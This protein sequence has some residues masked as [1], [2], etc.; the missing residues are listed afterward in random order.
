MQ[1]TIEFVSGYVRQQ[2]QQLE[3]ASPQSFAMHAHLIPSYD[4]ERV[5]STR[6]VTQGEALRALA[7]RLR[8]PLF[9]PGGALGE[10]SA[11][12]QNQLKAEA[13][14]LAEVFQRSSSN[15]EG[16]NGYRLRSPHRP[17]SAT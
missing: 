15:V 14:K 1:A 6:T 7:E 2:V 12:K 11:M 8:T 3:L 16:R 10:L 9:E 13:A 4:L 17:P 5:A